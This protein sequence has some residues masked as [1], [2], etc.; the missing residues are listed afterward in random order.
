MNSPQHT[1]EQTAKLD[2]F[3]AEVMEAEL[4]RARQDLHTAR[5]ALMNIAGGSYTADSV[6]DYAREQYVKAGGR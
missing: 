5:I 6:R 3:V 1:P 2:A 4:K